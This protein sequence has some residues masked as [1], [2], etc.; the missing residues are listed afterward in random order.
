MMSRVSA[1]DS[2]DQGSTP[3]RIILV[4]V[5]ERRAEGSLLN[6]YYTEV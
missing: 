4:V 6:S 5:V 2:V 1:N 3:G